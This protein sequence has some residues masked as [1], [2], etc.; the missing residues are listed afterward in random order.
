VSGVTRPVAKR[1]LTTLDGDVTPCS[2]RPV[3][4]ASL[5]PLPA[6][7]QTCL[8]R[9][10]HRER[11]IDPRRLWL[12]SCKL[13]RAGWRRSAKCIK[14]LNLLLFRAIL[15]E[16]ARVS[17]D[18]QLGHLALNVVIHPNTEIGRRCH[19]W[20][21]VTF[22]S[23]ATVGGDDWI[24]VGDD[25]EIGA[26]AVLVNRAGRTLRIGSGATIGANATVTRDVAPGAV[27]VG[28]KASVVRT[29]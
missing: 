29:S 23:D 26:G 21:G 18:I 27:M 8:V 13:Y 25:V 28:P 17:S 12:F 2:F 7:W 6:A 10:Y 1:W 9:P 22:A 20:H 11:I 3:E 16:E 14:G 19:I 4:G 15:P 24:I 5:S